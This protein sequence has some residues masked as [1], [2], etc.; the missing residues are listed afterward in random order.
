MDLYPWLV[1][2]HV[3]A[4][5]A[6]AMAH[7]VSAVVAFRVRA[8]RDPARMAALLDLSSTS[9][10][11]MYGSLVVLLIAGITAAVTHGWFGKGWPWAA[12]GVLIA[13]AVA[14]YGLASRYYGAIRQALGMP[15]YLDR[16][17]APS[18]PRPAEEVARLL[19]T[20]RPE[21]IAAV[22]FGGLLI[23]LWLMVVK[24]F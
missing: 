24:P 3:V 14:M 11:T 9:V 19:D 6:F 2:G 17:A 10:G 7:G 12:L 23:L 8:E 5:F 21:A 18:A 22:G 13:V 15:S 4:A 1:L 16:G 20:R